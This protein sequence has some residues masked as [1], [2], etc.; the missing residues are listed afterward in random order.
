MPLADKLYNATSLVRD[1]RWVGS[2]LWDR[3]NAGLT[4]QLWYYGTLA[5]TFA[6]HRPG[7]MADELSAAVNELRRLTEESTHEPGAAP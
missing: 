6:K 4:D 2:E 3:F 1:F 7:Q 5:E